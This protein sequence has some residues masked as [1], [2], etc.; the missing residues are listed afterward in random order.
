MPEVAARSTLQLL[1]IRTKGSKRKT[2]LDLW[3]VDD[4]APQEMPVFL[5][6]LLTIMVLMFY[7][8]ASEGLRL[9][10]VVFDGLHHVSWFRT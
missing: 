6:R 10:A 8:V 9:S 1:I 7:G 2:R 5:Q 4:T 3:N